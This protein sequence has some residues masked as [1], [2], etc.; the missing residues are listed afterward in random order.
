MP[1]LRRPKPE[2]PRGAEKGRVVRPAPATAN[3]KLRV[4]IPG[5]D[6]KLVYEIEHWMPRGAALPAVGDPVLVLHDDDG[7]PWVPSWRP[8]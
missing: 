4:V 2:I 3:D 5:F 6:K 1:K 7:D 8:A